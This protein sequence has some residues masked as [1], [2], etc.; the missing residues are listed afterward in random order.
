MKFLIFIT[1]ILTLLVKT[2]FCLAADERSPKGR[3][4]RFHIA[5]LVDKLDNTF[6][7][8]F[9]RIMEVAALQL[10][11]KVSIHQGHQSHLAMIEKAKQLAESPDRPDVLLFKSYKGNGQQILDIATKYKIKAFSINAPINFE[12]GVRERYTYLI[13]ELLPDD[14]QAG[15]ELLRA[16]RENMLAKNIKHIDLLAIN[17]DQADSPARLRE[18]GLKR[19]VAE[20]KDVT[21]HQHIFDSWSAAHVANRYEIL[22][23]RYPNVNAVW[24]GDDAIALEVVRKAK[25]LGQVPG[26]DIFIGGIDI[27]PQA[28]SAIQKGDLVTSVGGH[29]LDGA[30]A[31]VILYDYFKTGSLELDGGLTPML[32]VTRSQL[33]LYIQIMNPEKKV[34]LNFRQYSK[35]LYPK[36]SYDFRLPKE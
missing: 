4:K 16:L 10:D 34:P 23:K 26:R 12:P 30:R 14:E 33:P 29:I 8:N 19:A 35:T 7:A 6:W 28:L 9:V 15:Y 1:L 5:L 25:S 36:A 17:G 3:E 2:S 20:F 22:M 31:M 13:G 32:P 27:S 21:L 24:G 11:L 18:A